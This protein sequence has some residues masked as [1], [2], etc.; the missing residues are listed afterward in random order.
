MTGWQFVKTLGMDFTGV[1]PFES[2]RGRIHWWHLTWETEFSVTAKVT[3]F[4]RKVAI[5]VGE[6]NN[7]LFGELQA[8]R[9]L[10]YQ[11]QD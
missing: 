4:S 1:R 2:E 7:S 3:V 5:N 8:W 10:A 11:S 9:R 6:D